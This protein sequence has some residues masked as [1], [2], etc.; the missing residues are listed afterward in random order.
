MKE[1][2]KRYR[3]AYYLAVSLAL[4]LILVTQ[5]II[6]FSLAQKKYDAELINISG[7]QRMFCQRVL[8]QALSCQLNIEGL[9]QPEALANTYQE[10]ESDYEALK[11][12]DANLPKRQ[13]GELTLKFIQ[14]DGKMALAQ[15]YVEEAP[16]GL[17]PGQIKSLD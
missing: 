6:Q 11:A 13:E 10:W 16:A 3:R 14:L 7:R 2:S 1:H 12:A 17:T 15:T 5:S 8:S 4:L 9:C